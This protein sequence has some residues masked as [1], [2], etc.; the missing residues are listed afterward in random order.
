[1]ALRMVL[2]RSWGQLVES[3][4]APD[5]LFTRPQF[6]LLTES[7]TILHYFIRK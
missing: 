4:Q 7:S 2:E 3:I 6:I 5:N 1:M